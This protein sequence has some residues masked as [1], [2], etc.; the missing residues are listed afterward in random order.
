MAKDLTHVL[1]WTAVNEADIGSIN[2]GQDVSF[3]VDKYRD[4][5]FHGKVQKVRLEATMTQNVVTYI[6]EIATDNKDRALIPYLTANVS[7]NVAKRENV[8]KVPN[9]ALRWTPEDDQIAPSAPKPTSKPSKH[10]RTTAPSEE[11]SNR[12][13]TLWVLDGKFVRPIEVVAGASDGAFTEVSGADVKEGMEVVTGENTP[14]ASAS[15][16]GSQSGSN[17]PFAPTFPRGGRSGRGGGG[18]GR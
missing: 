2:A 15:A 13:G 9:T 8:L 14:N 6:V 3:T 4:R 10:K 12:P 5:T 16:G 11:T 18:G 1:I 17:N 7:F